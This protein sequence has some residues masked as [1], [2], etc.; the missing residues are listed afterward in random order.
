MLVE[1]EGMVQLGPAIVSSPFED[2]L[3]TLQTFDDL[4]KIVDEIVQKQC[5]VDLWPD[6]CYFNNGLGY[7]DARDAKLIMS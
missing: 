1:I 5:K 6:Q 4:E 2:N 7:C 3:Q